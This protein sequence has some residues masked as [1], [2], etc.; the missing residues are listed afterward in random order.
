MLSFSGYLSI[1]LGLS[2]SNRLESGEVLNHFIGVSAGEILYI[3]YAIIVYQLY[4]PSLI[5]K[6]LADLLNVTADYFDL[7][8]KY[9]KSEKVNE[10][11]VLYNLAQFQ[12][13]LNPKYDDIRDLLL[14]ERM[15]LFRSERHYERSLFIFIELIEMFELALITH[16]DPKKYRSLK[17][18]F[19]GVDALER[20]VGKMPEILRNTSVCIKKGKL[21][22]FDI[23]QFKKEMDS[24]RSEL[25]KAKSNALSPDKTIADYRF[26]NR[27]NIYLN[28]QIKKISRI[29]LLAAGE[30]EKV[31]MDFDPGRIDKFIPPRKLSIDA[32]LSN[33]TLDSSY[34]RYAL[35]MAITSVI[36]YVMAGFLDFQNPNWVLLTILVIMKPGYSITKNRL[37]QRII[38]TII[39]ALIVLPLTFLEINPLA[40]IL[41]MGI[42][43]FFAF[44]FLP[45]D[46]VKAT[47]FFTLFVLLLF[48][49]LTGLNTEIIFYRVI[50]T[51]FGGIL[52]FI[53]IRVIFP[54]WEHKSMPVFINELWQSNKNFAFYIL[55]SL[56]KESIDK[57]TYRELRK[58]TYVKMSNVISSYN[59]LITDPAQKRKIESNSYKLIMNNYA[60]MILASSIGVYLI[61]LDNKEYS[62][63]KISPFIE[64]LR[65]VLSSA[66][67]IN[68]D[69]TQKQIET[70]I[71]EIEE[72]LE[73]IDTP[74]LH[75]RFIIDQLMK[76][77]KLSESISVSFANQ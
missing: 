9:L 34:F 57:T 39:G 20:V 59:R 22:S 63:S 44:N 76:L 42:A 4:K 15:D 56:D 12:S 25:E 43:F 33:L 69:D 45:R 65:S 49:V 23:P 31:D 74:A 62:V 48:G 7:R 61:H 52:C 1:M 60:F 64:D 73:R 71:P 55:H 13:G 77:K 5:N 75:T 29:S 51:I 47:L 37:T 8:L 53:S 24:L 2:F 58:D 30:K 36:G 72:E 17:S 14:K 41:L 28:H 26:I 18:D 27:F 70:V 35:R 68:I 10:E 40:G 21:T 32:F 19:P 3:I 50:D 11:E 6:K 46:Y 54:F 67:A 38:G 66:N 16:F